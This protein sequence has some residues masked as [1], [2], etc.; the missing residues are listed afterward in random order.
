MKQ[1][2]MVRTNVRRTFV[3][4]KTRALK[5]VFRLLDSIP[6]TPHHKDES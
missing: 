4:E 3:A 2:G 5:Q 1:R 6:T